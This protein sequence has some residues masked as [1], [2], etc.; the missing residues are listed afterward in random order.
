MKSPN[1]TA[2]SRISDTFAAANI[3]GRDVLQD[4]TKVLGV[5][6]IGAG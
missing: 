6:L 1:V 4:V 5:L 3:E 2:Q